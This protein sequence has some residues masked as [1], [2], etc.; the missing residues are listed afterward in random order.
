MIRFSVNYGGNL[1]AGILPDSLPDAHHVTAGRVNN[2]A[3]MSSDLL[4]E[5]NF[6]TEGG[7][8][9]HILRT[10]ILDM[11][12]AVPVEHV[13]D[14]KR[15]DLGVNLGI[16]DDLPDQEESCL[17]ENFPRRVSEIDGPLNAVAE[18]EL[19]RE[20]DSGGPDPENGSLS[21]DPLDETAM[22]MVLDLLLHTGHDL[23]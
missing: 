10:E 2:A 15:G 18:S 12:P 5:G 17:W 16:V 19:L 13:T 6:R 7:N 14:P 1:F 4:E 21:A 9:D 22:V 20:A 3:S 23:R 8:N 11:R